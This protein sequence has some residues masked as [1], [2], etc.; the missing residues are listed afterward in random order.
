GL[1]ALAGLCAF[2]KP[3]GSTPLFGYG[4]AFLTVAG[5]AF[6]SRPAVILVSAVARP[7]AARLSAE[8]GSLGVDSYRR[9][10]RRNSVAVAALLVSVAMLVGLWTMIHS[11]RLTV[12]QWIAGTIRADLVVYPAG[13]FEGRRQG[14]LDPALAA[15]IEGLPGVQAVDRYREVRI[16]FRDEPVILASGQFSRLRDYRN[17]R[18]RSGD[19]REIFDQAGPGRGAVVTESFARRFHVWEGDEI[20]L[21]TSSGIRTYTVFGVFYDYSTDQGLILIDRQRFLDDFGDT[22]LSTIPVF[23]RPGIDTEG[24]RKAIVGVLDRPGEVVVQTN[25]EIREKVMEIFD[26]TFLLTKAL[27]LIAVAVAVLGVISA[28]LA[29]VVERTREMG[30]LRA[31]GCAPAQLRK[32]IL[33]EASLIGVTSHLLGSLGG[34]FLSLILIYVI[35]LQTF[36]WTIQFASP[37]A[38]VVEALVMVL[39]AALVG[40]IFPALRAGRV[41]VASALRYE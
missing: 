22:A 9:A 21:P 41:P 3:V 36:G 23:V 15:R 37:L 34:L 19:G 27:E 32:L 38:I 20:P 26:Q 24:V 4:A 13:H 28:L 40:G 2:Q 16:S 14:R 39:G 17:L 25:R 29:S 10:L 18:F 12:E 1:L 31:V 33:I 35:N 5:F 8:L 30:I 11:F 7:L 6:L